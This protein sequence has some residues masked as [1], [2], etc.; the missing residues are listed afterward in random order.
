VR[1]NKR[2][3]FVLLPLGLTACATWSTATVKPAKAET[4]V[5]VAVSP[6]IP[7]T[8]NDITDR[9]YKVLGDIKVTV[10]KTTIFNKD[11]T[12]DDVDAKLRKEAAKLGADAVVLVRYG[13]VGIGMTSWG[14]LHGEGR[15]VK[16]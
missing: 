3:W 2:F 4:S 13:T 12:H 11:P 7:L 14:V 8:E 9:P 10:H 6:E 5:A 15:A 16:F 1:L